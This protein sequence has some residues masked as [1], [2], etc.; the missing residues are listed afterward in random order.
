MK[1]RMLQNLGVLTLTCIATALTIS[2]LALGCSKPPEQAIIGRWDEDGKPG[3]IEFFS[4]NTF[5]VA[6]GKTQLSGRWTK[7]GDRR[8]KA[9]VSVLGMTKV[10]VFDDIEISGDKLSFVLDGSA[11]NFRRKR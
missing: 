3:F 4:D 10:L 1:H 5:L 11:G 2:I 6:N 8:I 7:V 9:E